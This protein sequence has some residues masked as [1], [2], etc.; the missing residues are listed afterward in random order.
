M[1]AGGRLDN[2][3]LGQ[4]LDFTVDNI[5]PHPRW[6]APWEEHWLVE[7]VTDCYAATT[8]LPVNKDADGNYTNRRMCG[9]YG[10]LN[11][12]NERDRY[13]MPIPEDIFDRIEG[14]CY[15]TIMDMR[16]D[17]N[18][19]EMRPEDKENIPLWASNRRW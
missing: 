5:P 19:I 4:L 14:C 13:P 8:V 16:Q 18:Q 10:M 15:F 7:P 11:L 17:F 1:A 9:D 6:T 3:K 12:K 2:P